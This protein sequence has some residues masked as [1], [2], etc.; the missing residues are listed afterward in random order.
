MSDDRAK[1]LAQLHQAYQSGILDED[2]Y[3]AAVAALDA[4]LT[5]QGTG[6][7]VATRGSV[8]VGGNV[9][10]SVYL[11]APP[12]DQ[13]EAL[14]IYRRMVQQACGTM[15]MRGVDV[16]AS[17]PTRGQE[18]L[19]LVSVYV[20]QN[21]TS[22]ISQDDGG[23]KKR[24]GQAD[25][26]EQK[27]RP[28]G[29]LEAVVANRYLVLLGDPGSGKSSFVNH[30]AHC[31]AGH[32]LEP[33]AGWL[34]LI[35]HWSLSEADTLPVMVILR[36]FAQTLPDP[37]PK[38]A[39]PSHLWG[40]LRSRLEA[41]N[42]TFAADPL[43]QLLEQ[44]KAL[45]L[46]D[47]LD[48]IALARQRVFMRDAVNTFIKRYPAN[49]Y[50]VTCRTL[51]YQGPTTADVPD[52]R[53][54]AKIPAFELA[55]FDEA[56][57]DRFIVAWY[58]E[59]AELGSVRAQD[60]PGLARQFQQAV[61]RVD[62][63]RLAPNPLLLTVMAL[64]H[65][66]KGRLP[67][68]RAL[69]YEDT[70]DILLWRWEQIKAGG[71]AAA[72][73]LRQLMLAADRTDMDL[74]RVLWGLAYEAHSGT[75]ASEGDPAEQEGLAN[76]GELKLQKALAGLK[77]NDRTWAWQVIE[78]MKLRAGL[79][80]ERI[81]EVFTFPHRTFQEYLAGAHLAAQGDFARQATALS[82]EGS[83]LWREVILLAVGRL[84]YLAGDTD[85]PLALVGELCSTRAGTEDRD[86]RK[87]WL[88]GE[89]LLEID[90]RRIEDRVLGQDLLSR[91]RS[92]LVKLLEQGQ[93]SPRERSA[94]GDVLAGLGDPGPGWVWAKMDYQK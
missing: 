86:W 62:L 25:I 64:V 78:A 29:V 31:L 32:D 1:R 44:G 66:H 37:L 67:D 54:A 52:M 90:P 39:Q 28:L 27:T 87:T 88:A 73:R 3:Q 84:V 4:K 48:E 55:L 34:E 9:Y 8:G 89:V 18:A 42:L 79:L 19:S 57:I 14:A 85:K 7:V 60:S 24:R 46:L 45:I 77:E 82:E 6:A 30:L 17:D 5:A 83:T 56:R 74:K 35:P 91:V 75:R 21:T 71:Q 50:L 51:S 69:L 10:G 15:P 58:A 61:R 53:L 11:G 93:L 49:R 16:G 92:R 81:P 65:T 80:L 38:Q 33:E 12:Q 59:L 13:T 23:G 70:V 26:R 63:W 68:A 43:H 76:I 41:Q 22:Q 2:T 94:A 40:F 36:D 20:D 47:G 72:P